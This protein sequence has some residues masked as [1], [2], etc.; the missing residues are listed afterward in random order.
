MGLK[1]SS[2]SI[3]HAMNVNVENYFHDSALAPSIHRDSQS[4]RESRVEAN[5]HKLLAILEEFGVRGAFFVL[6]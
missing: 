1:A 4:S 2:P 6:E 5:T 3:I